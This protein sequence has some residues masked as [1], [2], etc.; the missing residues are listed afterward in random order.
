VLHG[1]PPQNEAAPGAEKN[2][3]FILAL[4]NQDANEF[5]PLTGRGA[6]DSNQRLRIMLASHLWQSG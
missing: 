3:I 6:A 4:G 5:P 1:P 2:N